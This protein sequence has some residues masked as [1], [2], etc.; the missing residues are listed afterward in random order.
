M[1]STHFVTTVW[2]TAAAC[3]TAVAVVWPT[4]VVATVMAVPAMA[5]MMVATTTVSLSPSLHHQSFHQGDRALHIVLLLV[6]H[7]ICDRALQ[8]IT[9][10]KAIDRALQDIVLRLSIAMVDQLAPS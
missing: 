2:L 7:D 1:T 4:A 8:D 10:T 6:C 5:S 3:P 9:I